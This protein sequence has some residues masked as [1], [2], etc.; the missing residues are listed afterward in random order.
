MSENIGVALLGGGICFIWLFPA[1][2]VD[3]LCTIK[4]RN[5]CLFSALSFVIPVSP[6]VT[7]PLLLILPSKRKP[8]LGIDWRGLLLGTLG[9]PA[10]LSVVTGLVVFVVAYLLNH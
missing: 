9:L 1:M 5:S 7:I 4:G 10:L 8:P 3:R 2:I 6:L